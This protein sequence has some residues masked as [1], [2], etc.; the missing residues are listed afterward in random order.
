MA[1]GA[2]GPHGLIVIKPVVM[3]TKI[4]EDFA[5]IHHQH[6]VGKIVLDHR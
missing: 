6:M 1:I 4:E 5:I 3:D 2:N